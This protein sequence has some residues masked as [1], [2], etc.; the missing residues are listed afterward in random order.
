MAHTVKGQFERKYFQ[1]ISK[2]I[3]LTQYTVYVPKYIPNGN[4]VYIYDQHV[5]S[6][7][8]YYQ[9]VKC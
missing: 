2:I 1:H 7:G 6:I 5:N 9:N 4:Y 8:M 3:A